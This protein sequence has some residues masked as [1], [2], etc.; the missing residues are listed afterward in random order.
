M[1]LALKLQGA[2][3]L[4]VASGIFN[5]VPFLGVILAAAVPMLPA[6][7]Q[8]DTP[9]P[10]LII[11][12]TVVAVALY[13]G[14]RADTALYR[15]AREH[16]PGCR[17]GWHAVLGLAL[18]HHGSLLA[19]PLTA[20]V[21]LHLRLPSFSACTFPI[22]LRNAALVLADDAHA[23]HLKK[24]ASDIPFLDEQRA[25]QRQIRLDSYPATLYL[26]SPS[27]SLLMY[28]FASLLAGIT[29]VLQNG[30]GPPCYGRISR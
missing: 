9:G 27:I 29:Q 16:R 3:L 15:F 19:V 11:L 10:F 28:N 21:K 20:F 13:L 2:V 5:L 26:S 8:F 7:L 6:V 17:H 23:L 25:N 24:V 22:C 1:L 12:F 4:G 30:Q 14:E 18:G